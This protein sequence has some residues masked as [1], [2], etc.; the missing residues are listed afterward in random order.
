MENLTVITDEKI[1]TSVQIQEPKRLKTRRED[2]DNIISSNVVVEEETPVEEVKEVEAI[3]EIEQEDV[4]DDFKID[5]NAYTGSSNIEEDIPADTIQG[6]TTKLEG[7]YRGVN[8]RSTEKVAVEEKVEEP[9]KEEETISSDEFENALDV[10]SFSEKSEIYKNKIKGEYNVINE[11]ISGKQTEIDQITAEYGREKV[12]GSTLQDKKRALRKVTDG[13][14]ALD[15]TFIENEKDELSRNVLDSLTALF[16][17]RVDKHEE[18]CSEIKASDGRKKDLG[19]KEMSARD[20][21]KELKDKK[22]NF[23]NKY[24]PLL[25]EINEQDAKLKAITEELSETTGVYDEP[26]R[27]Q[28]YNINNYMEERKNVEKVENPFEGIREE[29]QSRRVA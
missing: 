1:K 12:I 21:L 8:P 19:Q 16:Q 20:E 23:V 2:Y 9:K 29:S 27:K 26:E 5:D 28:V 3:E 6:I 17:D 11:K 18:I 25:I 10:P 4:V 22:T 14:N 7:S 15:I 24:Y 13:I